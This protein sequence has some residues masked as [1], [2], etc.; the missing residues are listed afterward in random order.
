MPRG[1]A[2]Y[3]SLERHCAA[4]SLWVLCFDEAAFTAL[5]KLGLRHLRPISMRDFE[6]ADT[7]LKS[8]KENRSAIEYFFTCTPSLPRFVFARNPAVESITYVDADLF[9]FSDPEPIYAELSHSSIGI[10]SHRF[11]PKFRHLADHG[12]YNVGLLYFRN[13][14][15][16]LQCLD[17]WRQR[18][19]EW[20]YDRVEG[21]RFADQ[22]YL[23]CWPT[24]FKSVKIIQHKGV[25][26]APWNIGNYTL[27][28]PNREVTV[29]GDELI[30][31][32]FHGLNKLGAW[33]FDPTLAPY[34]VRASRL[35]RRH[36]YGPYLDVLNVKT[37][38]S[39][40]VLDSSQDFAN[41]RYLSKQRTAADTTWLNGIVQQA[42][43]TCAIVRGIR[44]RR[45]LL[46]IG[47]YAF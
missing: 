32:H 40:R 15:E 21:C 3:E 31:Y 46:N 38:I 42:K 27:R 29:D 47:G 28:M 20:C 8:A 37:V 5:S 16:G 10:I 18:C 41:S 6:D 36:I 43:H 44:E 1:L 2:L 13:N 22:K 19:L 23:D 26:L 4:F 39:Q 34:D 7:D 11:A 25:N 30:V 17:W 9:F 45:Y 24:L 14:Q 12:E 35:I 33:A